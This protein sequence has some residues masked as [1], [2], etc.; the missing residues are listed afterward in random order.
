M[1]DGSFD[2]V[3]SLLCL[4]NIEGRTGQVRSCREIARVLKPGGVALIADYVPT[5]RYASAFAGAGLHVVSSRPY[6]ATALSLM[7]VVRAEKPDRPPGP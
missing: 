2:R 4:H 1:P 7:W 3:L 5:G 6:F